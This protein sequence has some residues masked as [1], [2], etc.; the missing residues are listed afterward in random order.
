MARFLPYTFE[1]TASL[2]GFSMPTFDFEVTLVSQLIDYSSSPDTLFSDPYESFEY[3]FSNYGGTE[4][5]YD[6]TPCLQDGVSSLPKDSTLVGLLWD[7]DSEQ[8]EG[9]T[10]NYEIESVSGDQDSGWDYSYYLLT[11]FSAQT[12]AKSVEEAIKKIK[13]EVLDNL[14]IYDGGVDEILE[15][16]DVRVILQAN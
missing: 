15:I 5:L 8:F 13:D 16:E 4:I 7:S 9:S 6:A 12:S 2:E 3:N 11:S 14:A 1:L 10:P